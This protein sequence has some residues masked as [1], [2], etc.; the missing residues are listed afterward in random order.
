MNVKV[1]GRLGGWLGVYGM[2]GVGS[3][4]GSV[5]VGSA[6]KQS[7]LC[8]VPSDAD[9]QFV[10][11]PVSRVQVTISYQRKTRQQTYSLH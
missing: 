9:V 3:V 1:G 5:H 6:A 2:R 4:Y 8:F 7:S 10:N 11:P